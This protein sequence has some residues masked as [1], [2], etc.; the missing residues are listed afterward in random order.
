M[1]FSGLRNICA[2]NKL[3]QICDLTV[4]FK[5]INLCLI[6]HFPQCKLRGLYVEITYV[7]Y[8]SRYMLHKKTRP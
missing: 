2:F 6:V 1:W 7:S 3:L 4:C 5:T 8:T